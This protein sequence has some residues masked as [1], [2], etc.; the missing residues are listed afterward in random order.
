MKTKIFCVVPVVFSNILI[1][2][3]NE[4]AIHRWKHNSDIVYNGYVEQD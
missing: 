2:I 3:L 4:D 1:C